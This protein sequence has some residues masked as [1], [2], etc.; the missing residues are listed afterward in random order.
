MYTPF[1]RAYMGIAVPN[2]PNYFMF[3]GPA[4][5]PASGSFIPTLELVMDYI[6]ECI[7]KLQRESYGWMETM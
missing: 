6:V 1:P 7:S 3:L 5:A 4:S 2:M